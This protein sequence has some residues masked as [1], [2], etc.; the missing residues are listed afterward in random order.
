MWSDDGEAGSKFLDR[1]GLI[2]NV[3]PDKDQKSEK[4]SHASTWGREI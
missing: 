3:T 1:E 4:A 2:E